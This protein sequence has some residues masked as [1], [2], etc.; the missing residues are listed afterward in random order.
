MCRAARSLVAISGQRKAVQL[1]R[2]VKIARAE[3][4]GV[5]SGMATF[6]QIWNSLSPSM[7]AAWM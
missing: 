2:N 7:R 5:T 6:H 1:P 3:S 4:A